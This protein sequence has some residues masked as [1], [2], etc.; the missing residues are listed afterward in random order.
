MIFTHLSTKLVRF[1]P[2]YDNSFLDQVHH[3]VAVGGKC[4]TSAVVV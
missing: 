2:S 1:E 3:T 4:V